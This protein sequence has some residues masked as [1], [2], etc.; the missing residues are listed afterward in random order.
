MNIHTDMY[1]YRQVVASVTVSGLEY[2]QTRARKI[3]ETAL[4]E[5]DLNLKPQWTELTDEPH[6]NIILKMS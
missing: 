3:S 5:R 6:K 4:K 2:P 1:I